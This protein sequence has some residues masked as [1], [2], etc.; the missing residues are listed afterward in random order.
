ML[1]RL[2]ENDLGGVSLLASANAGAAGAGSFLQQAEPIMHFLV[3]LGQV[4]VAGVTVW[5]IIRKIRRMPTGDKSDRRVDSD[6]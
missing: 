3:A 4:L 6:E 1:K 2:F 5:F